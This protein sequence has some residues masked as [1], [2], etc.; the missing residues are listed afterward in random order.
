MNNKWTYY[1]LYRIAMEHIDWLAEAMLDVEKLNGD[2]Q[3]YETLDGKRFKRKS[4]ALDHQ[5]DYLLEE[6]DED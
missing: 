4:D 6:D 2:V 5:I 1:K 3:Y